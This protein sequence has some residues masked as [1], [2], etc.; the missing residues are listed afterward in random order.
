MADNPK[1]TDRYQRW[2][3]DERRLEEGRIPRGVA[4]LPHADPRRS[5]A[6]QP[7]PRENMLRPAIEG[8]WRE[9]ADQA[10]LIRQLLQESGGPRRRARNA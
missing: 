1:E 9:Y 8:R 4:G 10:Q 6:S 5:L 3:R 7:D 2:W